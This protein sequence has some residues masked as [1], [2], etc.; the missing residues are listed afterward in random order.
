MTGPISHLFKFLKRVSDADRELRYFL[1]GKNP[2]VDLMPFCIEADN[3]Q[4]LA[5]WKSCGNVCV[6][7]SKR[8][9]KVVVVVT[10]VPVDLNTRDTNWRKTC[11]GYDRG[12]LLMQDW[13]RLS[14]YSR[15]ARRQLPLIVPVRGLHKLV[16]L[17]AFILFPLLA[18][19]SEKARRNIV[20][21]DLC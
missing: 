5:R 16:L 9:T 14:R 13:L 21:W 7:F 8:K 12:I 6:K 15:E 17:V 11:D 1:H 2:N 3:I 10:R 20:T 19:R 4:V 18:L